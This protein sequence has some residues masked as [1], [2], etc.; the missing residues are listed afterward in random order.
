MNSSYHRLLHRLSLIIFKFIWQHHVPV[1]EIYMFSVSHLKIVT[2]AYA[3][4]ELHTLLM[5]ITNVNLM[6]QL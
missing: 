6:I 5:I 4:L 1:N 2:A 3:Y